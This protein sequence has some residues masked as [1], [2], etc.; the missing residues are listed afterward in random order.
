MINVP[1]AAGRDE[2][3]VGGFK[4]N[5]AILCVL[6]VLILLLGATLLM[7]MK[8]EGWAEGLIMKR[9]LPSGSQREISKGV[10]LVAD[11]RLV[12]PN[13]SKTVVLV[14]RH[15]S[16]GT[17]GIIINRPTK[18]RLSRLLPDI[19]ELKD[20]PDTLYIGGPVLHEVVLLLLRTKD[21][22]KSA[23]Q[24]FDNVYFSPSIEI[25]TAMLRKNR[26]KDVVRVYSGHAGWAPGQLQAETD[27]G[28]WRIIRADPDMVF[29][30]DPAAV[31]AEMIRRSSEQLIK[32]RRRPY[33]LIALQ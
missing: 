15:G 20:R 21:P 25:L 30:K 24:V 33:Q 16:E 3:C 1:R 8:E 10:F 14:I 27:R 9:S 17:M 19:K 2:C 28:D 11:P 4:W 32:D 5:R 13:F 6:A 12:D 29:E 26:P 7:T 22:L 23:D 18:T 31:W